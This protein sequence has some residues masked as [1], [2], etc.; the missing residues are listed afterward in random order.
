MIS[1]LIIMVTGLATPFAFDFI[2]FTI[3]RFIMGLG[4]N[5]YVKSILV[6]TSE[7][8]DKSKRA[9]VGNL[10]L[11]IAMSFGGCI[12]PWIL[13]LVGDWRWFHHIL[14]GQTVL[15]FGAPYFVKESSRWLITKGKID[16]AV[17]IMMEIAKENG[18]EVNPTIVQ[19]FK[20]SQIKKFC[21]SMYWNKLRDCTKHCYD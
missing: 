11:A 9:L 3:L 7:Y 4:F 18:K 16:E 19:S 8:V 17:K 1:N 6:L 15:I 2:S 5:T 20:V 13:Y 21:T 12:Q 10:A 14:F